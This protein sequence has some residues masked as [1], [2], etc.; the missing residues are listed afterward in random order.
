MLV[1]ICGSEDGV[2]SSAHLQEDLD[3]IVGRGEYVSE[4]VPGGHGFLLDKAASEEVVGI[5]RR[6]WNL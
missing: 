5:L 2:V 4:E 1:V 6:E 3:A